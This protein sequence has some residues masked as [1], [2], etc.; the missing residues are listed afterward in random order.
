MEEGEI[1][2][3]LNIYLYY[4]TIVIFI[5]F[6]IIDS[7]A[8][9]VEVDIQNFNI[10][11]MISVVTFLFGFL[12][13]ISFSMLLTRTAE[14]REVIAVETGRLVS[15]YLLSKHLG[16]K[17]HKSIE[18]KIDEYT[19]RTLR[20]YTNY[21]VGREIIY[22]MNDD[23]GLVELKNGHQQSIYS[24]LLYILGELEP[25]RERLESLTKN[26]LLW[27]LKLSNYLL[28][29]ILVVLLFFNRGDKFSNILFIILSTIVVFIL[30]IIEDYDSLKIEAY[31]INIDDSEQI[32]DLI[33]RERYYP[34]KLLKMIEL[35]KGK[36]YR[37]GI[38]DSKEKS[39]K[40]VRLKY[41][42][43]FKAS[44]DRIMKRFSKK[45]KE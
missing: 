19:I 1:K 30:L 15:I 11:L 2:R 5:G 41:T 21:Q 8:K 4:W 36:V 42:P 44:L 37:V 33:G 17:F 40:I 6:L 22:Q 26:K 10:S 34:E 29:V 38:Y 45:V 43:Y 13:T 25:I 12:I 3:G 31:N 20:D 18:N 9:N 24:S 14:L 7:L 32:F 35:E 16:D 23:L 39:E 27:S 28:G